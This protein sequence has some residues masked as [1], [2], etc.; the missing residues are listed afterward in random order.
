MTL[1]LFP[2]SGVPLVV[3]PYQDEDAMESIHLTQVALGE[4]PGK[5]PHVVFVQQ[6]DDKIAIG[7]LETGRC[8]QFQVDFTLGTDPVHLSH[9]GDSE[10]F[11][12]GYRTMTI[13][14][15]MGDMYDDYEDSDEDSDEEIDS[16]E[17]PSSHEESDEGEEAPA[18]VPMA[19]GGG[20]KKGRVVEIMGASSEDD[21]EGDS[22]GDFED[23]S[24][25]D[26]EENTE[27]QSSEEEAPVAPTSGK[28]RAAALPAP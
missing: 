19:N 8:A 24:E 5:K 14:P 16:D 25:D 1:V 6:G 20:S 15:E 22:E 9:S 12:S 7:T 4:K 10:V 3:E 23:D 2:T 18:A 17:L 11:V 26:S 13:T 21:S 27:T 28:K